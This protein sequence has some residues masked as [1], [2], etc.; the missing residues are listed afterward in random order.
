MR[1]NEN[2]VTVRCVSGR[3]YDVILDLRR[4]SPAFL[5]WMAIELAA[6]DD[7]MLYVPAGCAHGFQTLTDNTELSYLLTEEFR[8]GRDLGVRWNDPAFGI[9]WPT[10]CTV[11]SDRDATY[12]DFVV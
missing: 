7:R 9:V 5:K 1:P 12:P 11:M 4:G 6:G 8:A 3:A 2:G 10:P